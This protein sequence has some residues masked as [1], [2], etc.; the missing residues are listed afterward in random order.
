MAFAPLGAFAAGE[1]NPLQSK[2]VTL[3]YFAQADLLM[4]VGGLN[5]QLGV[6]VCLE[7]APAQSQLARPPREL[8]VHVQDVPAS[9]ALDAIT[10]ATTTY[11]WRVQREPLT[12][13][14]IPAGLQGDPK[15]TLNRKCPACEIKDASMREAVA[16][17]S[18]AA[19][20]D[21]KSG[22]VKYLS[23]PFS[24]SFGEGKFEDQPLVKFWKRRITVKVKEGTVRSALNQ[25]AHAI[26]GAWW[27]YGE[28]KIGGEMWRRVDFEP[29]S[30]TVYGE[31]DP[32]LNHP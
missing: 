19:F 1:E 21:E 16:A 28:H 7:F 10:H 27:T 13:N 6:P 17:L 26:G 18:K 15:W 8:K 5:E 2:R 22:M 14:L 29:L 23:P 31:P 20:P 24:I 4:I 25:M 9:Q 32:L 30:P 3:R 12:V 11:V